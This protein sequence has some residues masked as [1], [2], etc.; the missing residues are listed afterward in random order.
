TQRDVSQFEV[1]GPLQGT[2]GQ[3]AGLQSAAFPMPSLPGSAGGLPVQFVITTGAPFEELDQVAS[4]L[5]GAAMG[6]G[7]FVFLQK[8]VEF[9]RPV[10]RILVD[11]DRAGDL[12]ISMQDVGVNLARMLGGG[13]VNRFSLEGR[14]Y[15]VIPQ[16]DRRHRL[17]TEMLHDYYIR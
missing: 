6:S 4:E 10:T 16:V 13:E 12:G 9:D 3:V 1:L 5:L 8:S 11:R 14:S 15:K 17:D 2:I 7:N